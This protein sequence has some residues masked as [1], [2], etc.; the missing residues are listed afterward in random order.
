MKLLIIEDDISTVESI[1]FCLELYEPNS[2]LLYTNKGLEAI[3][4]LNNDRFDAVIIDVGLPDIDGIDVLH[5]LRQ[6]SATPAI[7]LSAKHSNEVISKA[8]EYGA[9]DYITKPFNYKKLLLR[10]REFVNR[11]SQQLS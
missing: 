6:F 3:K 9:N 8:L 4:M 5:Q 7:V 11:P 1:K 2:T 10:L